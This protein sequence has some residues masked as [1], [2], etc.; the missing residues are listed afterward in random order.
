M[1]WREKRQQVIFATWTRKA[2]SQLME[3][4]VRTEKFRLGL[5]LDGKER[6]KETLTVDE[7]N[8]SLYLLLLKD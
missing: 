7:P 2:I 4:A 3:I 6:L 8:R 1:T 5:I